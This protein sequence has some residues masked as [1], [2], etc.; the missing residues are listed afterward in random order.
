MNSKTAKTAL[1]RAETP[2]SHRRRT[3]VC[4]TRALIPS[5]S[6][7]TTTTKASGS[8]RSD[9]PA[10]S[11]LNVSSLD[12]IYTRKCIGTGLNSIPILTALVTTIQR[13]TSW[14]ISLRSLL[15]LF[16][17]HQRKMKRFPNRKNLKKVALQRQSQ[18]NRLLGS[19]RSM[20][21]QRMSSCLPS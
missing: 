10:H 11:L 7:T 20:T 14:K 19:G 15:L 16:L 4:T 17:N 3:A 6:R 2:C 8:G 9:L 18:V 5:R 1:T 13:K 12:I 21:F